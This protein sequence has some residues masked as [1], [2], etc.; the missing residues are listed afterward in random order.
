MR[1]LIA[2]S[3][4]RRPGGEDRYVQQQIQLLR[5]HHAVE[6]F[7]RRNDDLRAGM[8]T[9]AEMTASAPSQ[10][11]ALR[12]AIAA[13]RPDLIHLHNAYPGLG[14]AVH[15]EAQRA[16]VPLVMTVHNSRLRCP[17][18][19]MFTEGQPCRRCESGNYS[20]ALVHHCFS[21]GSQAL[22]YAGSLWLHRFFLQLDKKVTAF[23]TP[24]QFMYDRMLDWGF[25]EPLLSVVRNFTDH[26]SDDTKP[27]EYGMC[28]GRLSSEK[29]LDVLLEAL[30]LAGDPPFHIVGDGPL[31][32]WLQQI[33]EEKRLKNTLFL[34]RLSTVEVAQQLQ[35]S[36]FLAVPSLCDENAPLAALEAMAVGR[37]LIVSEMGGLPELVSSG[38]GLVCR[39][40]DARD[41]AEKIL[42]LLQ[43]EEACLKAGSA[44]LKRAQTEF[45]PEVHLRG[46]E[47]VYTRVTRSVG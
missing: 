14:P 31:M 4:Y 1:V 3:F 36:R 20:N 34:G 8:S 30:A 7:S 47:D 43:S 9:A 33:A 41:L 25:P 24:S 42:L 35:G 44:A 11:R 26:F 38:E 16:N 13:F 12:D 28:L 18:G 17:N 19:Y 29:G 40:H 5:L 32:T 22:T 27:G 39:R 15:L 6:L 2:H 46:L 45:T 21:T 37:P 10:R 23:I